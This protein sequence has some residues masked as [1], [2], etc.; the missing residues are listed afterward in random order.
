M[1]RRAFLTLVGGLALPEVMLMRPAHAEGASKRPLIVWLTVARGTS[2][3]RTFFATFVNGM[4]DQG[5]VQGR[6]FDLVLRGAEG[7]VDRLPTIMEQ[8][9]QLK[10][11]VILAPATFEAVAASA[12]RAQYRL[13]AQRWPMR[14][15]WV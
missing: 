9:I 3:G 15:I 2:V 6:D 13:S 8:V 1:R 7:A 12:R 14:S 4:Q 11:D 10:P 5:Y